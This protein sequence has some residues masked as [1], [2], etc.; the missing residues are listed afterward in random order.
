V[1]HLP[2]SLSLLSIES[3]MDSV[4]MFRAWLKRFREPLLVEGVDGV[5]RRLRI[6]AQLVSDLVGVFAPVA[7]EQDL[8]TGNGAG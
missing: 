7:G 4:R 2:Q 5:A 6:A 3:P 1:K 8:A